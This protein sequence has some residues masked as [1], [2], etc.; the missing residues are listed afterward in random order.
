MSIALK[1]LLP[2]FSLLLGACFSV[3]KPAQV[4]LRIVDKRE[5]AD[6]RV[7]ALSTDPLS[8]DYCYAL[9]VTGD[10]RDLRGA[11]PLN[12]SCSAGAAF[13]GQTSG[14]YKIGDRAEVTVPAGPKRRFD[15]LAFPKVGDCSGALELSQL[16][17]GRF[18]AKVGGQ[19]VA[20]EARVAAT[21]T[22]DIV[23]GSQTVE[24]VKLTSA[25][26]PGGE[27]IACEGAPRIDSVTS[28]GT[29]GF[30]ISGSGLAG[31]KTVTLGDTSVGF[32]IVSQS[33]SEILARAT[34]VIQFAMGQTYKLIVADAAGQTASS[35]LSFALAD[36]SVKPQH[37]DLNA[38]WPFARVINYIPSASQVVAIHSGVSMFDWPLAFDKNTATFGGFVVPDSFYVSGQGPTTMTGGSIIASL[39]FGTQISATILGS[40]RLEPQGGGTATSSANCYL[41]AHDNSTDAYMG[42]ELIPGGISLTWVSSPSPGAMAGSYIGTDARFKAPTFARYLNFVC[43]NYSGGPVVLRLNEL[44]IQKDVF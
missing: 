19:A 21:V 13:L 17:A 28:S 5:G 27:V 41:R 29:D 43:S 16:A 32:T 36:G 7:S 14:L 38:D 34:S 20:S 2:G 18:T 4:S 44:M 35:T 22:A 33:A 12:T 11:N 25:D 31:V 1:H 40:I 6:R 10:H 42:T 24:L 39:D 37:L 8:G 26:S 30:R 15:L 23:P 3:S 9:N